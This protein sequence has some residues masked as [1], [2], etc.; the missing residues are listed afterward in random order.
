LDTVASLMKECQAALERAGVAFGHGTDNARDEAAWLVLHVLRQPLDGHFEAWDAEVTQGQAEVV[1]RLLE[2]R[3]GC[4]APLAYLI[5]EA[6]FCGLRFE[7]NPH[8]LVPR[9]PIAELIVRQF[10]PWVMPGRLETALDL[11]TGSGCIAVA[12]AVHC[13][14]LRVTAA[15]ISSQALAVAQRNIDAHRVGS[16]VRLLESDLFTNLPPQRFNLIVSNPPYVPRDAIAKLPAEY[17]AEPEIA[18][19]SGADGLDLP[20]RILRDSANYLND[21]GLLVCEVGEGAGRLQA[22]LPRAGWTWL[23]FEHGGE[24]VFTMEREALIAMQP[25]LRSVM[26]NR[27]DVV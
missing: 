26:E 19:A 18:L 22:L 21:L 4:R 1:R 15:D 6:W 25:A 7:V 20:L 8:V 13:P 10:Q 2:A 16:R 14:G 9:S 11:C 5:G 3:I 23:E 24:G 17:R 27:K 12:M